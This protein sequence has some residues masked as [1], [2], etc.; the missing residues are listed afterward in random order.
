MYIRYPNDR[1]FNQL[2]NGFKNKNNL[3]NFIINQLYYF[4]LNL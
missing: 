3:V 1:L 2:K 4:N